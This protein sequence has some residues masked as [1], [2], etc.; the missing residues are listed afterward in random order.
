MASA[1]PAPGA[2]SPPAD[3]AGR[4]FSIAVLRTDDRLVLARHSVDAPP[5][6]APATPPAALDWAAIAAKVAAAAVN[7]TRLQLD[8]ADGGGSGGGAQV[9]AVVSRPKG[10]VVAAVCSAATS[11]RTAFVLCDTALAQFERMFPERAVALSAAQCDS[12]APL[13]ADGLVKFNATMATVAAEDGGRVE[14]VKRAVEDTKVTMLDNIDRALDRGAKIETIVEASA[15][16]SHNAETFQ[17]HA[18]E[19]ERAMWWRNVRTKAIIAGV[20]ALICLVLILVACGKKCLPGHSDAA[21]RA[22]TSTPAPA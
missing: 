10:I 1:V 15:D 18:H 4:C 14:R 12:F 6:G 20:A 21:A 8:L 5:G 17:R 22:H 13:L 19:L 11:A 9:H 7:R 3:V 2:A 16:L